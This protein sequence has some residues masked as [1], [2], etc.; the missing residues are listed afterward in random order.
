LDTDLLHKNFRH[1]R[2]T[3]KLTINQISAESG[4]GVP[5]LQKM[6]DNK[7]KKPLEYTNYQSLLDM[8]NLKLHKKL[9]LED[10]YYIDIENE[11][12]KIEQA[13]FDVKE[14]Y[15]DDIEVANKHITKDTLNQE[16]NQYLKDRYDQLY[17]SIVEKEA[18]IAKS[19]F[20]VN[21]NQRQLEEMK[22]EFDRIKQILESH[23]AEEHKLT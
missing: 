5:V 6:Q 9:K 20:D 13:V 23:N 22:L 18:L 19:K 2:S 1:L 12:N 7:L 3:T 21:K 14:N 10:L 17:F 15:N 11:S 8:Y 4:I 16:A